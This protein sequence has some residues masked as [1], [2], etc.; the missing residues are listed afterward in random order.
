MD[1]TNSETGNT[2][3]AGKSKY[4]TVRSTIAFIFVISYII[5]CTLCTQP[6]SKHVTDVQQ[7]DDGLR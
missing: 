5:Y 4:P 3:T 7:H 2:S 1:S 6:S